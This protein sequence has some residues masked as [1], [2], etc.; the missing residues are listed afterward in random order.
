VR[1]ERL[2]DLNER[3]FDVGVIVHVESKPAKRSIAF[4]DVRAADAVKEGK[5][6]PGGLIERENRSVESEVMKYPGSS[7]RRPCFPE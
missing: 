4:H 6:V 2:S 7:L 3:S 5:R 1:G